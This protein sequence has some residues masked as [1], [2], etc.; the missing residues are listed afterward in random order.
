[1]AP[2]PGAGSP[3]SLGRA[4]VAEREACGDLSFPFFVSLARNRQ[5]DAQVHQLTHETRY[6]RQYRGS[7]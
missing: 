6:K 1:M 3:P 2:L 5:T 4:I 7:R